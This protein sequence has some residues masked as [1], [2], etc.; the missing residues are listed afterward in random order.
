MIPANLQKYLPTVCPSCGSTLTF[1]GIHLMCENL[2]CPGIVAK[3]L[4]YQVGVLDL[5]QVGNSTIVPFAKD[6]PNMYRIFQYIL[7]NHKDKG[8]SLERYG[9]RPGT[10]SHE[11]FV[12]AFTN[13]K[14][15]DYWKVILLLGYDG[16]GKKVAQQAAREYCG[17]EAN[18][19]GLERALVSLLQTEDIRNYINDCI[20]F[21][22]SHGVSIDRP[23]DLTN[24]DTI[25]IC[26]TGS[27]KEFGYKTK[28]EFIKQF[29]NCKE[30]DL[31]NASFLITDSYTSTSSKMGVA[32][33]KGITIKTYGDFKA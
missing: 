24:G 19:S 3:K 15:L 11:I 30:S 18:Y 31:K 25:F 6:F 26:M 23:M 8:F 10:R 20:M 29:P 21:L 7:L 14:S 9:I 33:K 5:K 4:S 13:I 16:V 12:S 2:L 32:K 22:E 1:D 27:P 17:L 28:D